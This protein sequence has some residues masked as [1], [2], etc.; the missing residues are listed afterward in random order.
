[1]NDRP[2]TIRARPNRNRLHQSAAVRR[3][4]SRSSIEVPT[5]QALRT[6]IA[7]SRPFGESANHQAA[8]PTSKVACRLVAAT[9]IVGWRPSASILIGFV[10]VKS[11]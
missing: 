10:Q 3:A 5:P 7:V 2:F 1:M 4:I 9:P 8:V 6:V 11:S